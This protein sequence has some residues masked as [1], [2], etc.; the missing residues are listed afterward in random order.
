MFIGALKLEQK[1]KKV[2]VV[3]LALVKL[4]LLFFN[5]GYYIYQGNTWKY[6]CIIY[7]AMKILHVNEL[8]VGYQ[9]DVLHM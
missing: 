9:R 2:G 1:F 8:T 7:I 3:S 6:T 4:V 5:T